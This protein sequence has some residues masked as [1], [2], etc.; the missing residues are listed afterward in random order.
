MIIISLIINS[1]LFFF[2]LNFSYMK[3]KKEN[4]NYPNK[5]VS[6]LLLFPL[7]LGIVFTLVMDVFK[8][9]MIYQLV[10]FAVAALLLYWI[11]YVLSKK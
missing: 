3:R 4:P 11:F 1:L 6:Q 8:G 10:L 5:P 2:L 9:F 7:A